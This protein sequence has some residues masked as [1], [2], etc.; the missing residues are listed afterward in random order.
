MSITSLTFCV[1]STFILLLF[2]QRVGFGIASVSDVTLTRG[3]STVFSQF[4]LFVE[5]LIFTVGA[6]LVSFIVFLTMAQRT[7][8]FGLIKAAGCPNG[9]VFGYFMTELLVITF[10]GCL[11]GVVLGFAGDFVIGLAGNSQIPQKPPDLWL[12]PLLFAAYFI[13]ALIFGVKP[14]H[15]ASKMPSIEAISPTRYFGL[16]RGGKLKALSGS[17]MTLRIALRFLFRHKSTTVRIILV[18]SVIFA[19]LTVSIAGSIIARDTTKSWIQK[20]TERGALLVAHSNMCKQYMLLLS[21][22]SGAE[23]DRDFDYL[24][25]ELFISDSILNQLNTMP[26]ISDVDVR[27]IL[28]VEI[29]EL[30]CYTIDPETQATIQVGDNREGDSLIIGVEPRTA[31]DTW[32]MQG[33]FLHADSAWE[34]VIGDSIAH[35]MFSLPLSQS[36]VVQDRVFSIVGVRPDPI[37]NG[38]VTYV[39]LEKLQRITNI[40]CPN[41]VLVRM[42]PLADRTAALTTLQERIGNLSSQLTVCELDEVD[43]RNL[44]FLDS[45]WSTLKILPLFTLT[46]AASCLIGFLVLVTDEQRQEFGILRAA[47]AKPRTVTAILSAQSILVLLLSCAAGILFGIMITLLILVP[48]PTVTTVAILEITGWLLAAQLGVFSLCLW[49]ATRFAKKPILEILSK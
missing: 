8:D 41:A 9:L 35:T 21:Q 24:D 39:P 27:L 18:L 37:N 42:N 43:E 31:L 20:T 7:R 46:S 49:Y 40:T 1:T 4:M 19:L 12:A 32:S 29:R 28:E 16:S 26:G 44:N 5:L 34:A 13:F 30:A 3:L 10:A 25:E 22:F 2:S 14:I 47:G 36:V 45:L 48:G 6:V 15:D 11:F 17:S 33:R 23:E 38:K